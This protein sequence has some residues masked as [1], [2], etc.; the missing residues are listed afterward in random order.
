MQAYAARQC[1]K[2]D[3]QAINWALLSCK[4]M[5]Q[6]SAR[7]RLHA[8]AY[9]LGVFPQGTERPEEIADWTLTRGGRGISDQS[10]RWIA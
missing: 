1:I 3:K 5:A 7:L 9:N 2:E 8:P 6:N 10:L 4:G